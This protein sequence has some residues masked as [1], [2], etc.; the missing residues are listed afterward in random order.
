MEKFRPEDLHNY[1]PRIICRL[2]PE[3]N[4]P[5]RTTCMISLS[6]LLPQ[7]EFYIPLKTPAPKVAV[8]T[9]ELQV[10]TFEQVAS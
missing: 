5:K 4:A 10:F 1:P 2:F 8:D 9:T 6:G 3:E 7:V